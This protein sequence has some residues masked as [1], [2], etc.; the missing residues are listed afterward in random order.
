MTPRIRAMTFKGRVMTAFGIMVAAA[1]VGMM[2]IA[3]VDAPAWAEQVLTGVLALPLSL[4]VT[5]EMLRERGH[6]PSQQR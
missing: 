3:A 5:Y 1:C 2:L 4:Y 6:L